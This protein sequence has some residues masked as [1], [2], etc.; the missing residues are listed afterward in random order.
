MAGTFT[1]S[2]DA[3]LGAYLCYESPSFSPSCVQEVMLWCVVSSYLCITSL[4]V[5]MD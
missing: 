1:V 5:K 4:F 2:I 3:A